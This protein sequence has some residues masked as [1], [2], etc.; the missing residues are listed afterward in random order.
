[1][2]VDA[3]S[4]AR[5]WIA[6]WNAR[7]LGAILSHYAADIVFLS[8]YAEHVIGTGR[9]E[10]LDALRAYWRTGLDANPELHFE[11]EAVLTGYGALTILYRN[12]RRQQ[13]AET[14]EFDESSRVIR[15]F[16]CY[17]SQSG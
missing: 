14:V 16:A 6:A 3:D 11:F 1:M 17:G 15:S 13:V 5:D 10:G 7:D 12:H 8:P 2:T 9:V 4:F